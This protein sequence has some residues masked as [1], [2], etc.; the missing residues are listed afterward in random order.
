MKLDFYHT[1]V[2]KINSKWIR[3][4]NVRSA[5]VKLSGDNIEKIILTLVWP[6]IFF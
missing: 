4:L 6:M 2:T 3:D 1:P 5:T